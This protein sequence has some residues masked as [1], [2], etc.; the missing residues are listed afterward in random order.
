MNI[1]IKDKNKFDQIKDKILQAGWDKL[2]ILSDFDRTLT[3]GLVDGKKSSSLLS[4]FEK[5]CKFGEEYNIQ[6]KA[7]FDKYYPIEVDLSIPLEE[8]KKEMVNWWLEVYNLFVK[9]GLKKSDL[10]EVIKSSDLKLRDGVFEFLQFLKEKNIPLIIFSATG[11]GEMVEMFLRKNNCNFPNIYYIVNKLKWD[12]NG[13]AV[14]VYEPIIHSLNKDETVVSDFPEIFA[15]VKDRDNGLL[16]GDNIGD[17]GMAQGFNF[18]NLLKIGFLNFQIEK[19]GDTYANN[20]D[21]VVEGDGDFSFV[22]DIFK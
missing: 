4:L 6:A 19:D 21:A 3:Y 11:C 8:R 22:L 13:K 17:L 18:V 15:L 5:S 16:L 9:Y 14:S 7:L 20:F 2:Q 12:E 10:E 1:V